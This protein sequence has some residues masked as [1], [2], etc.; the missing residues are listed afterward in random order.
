MNKDKAK[1]YHKGA[2]GQKA[3]VEVL[4]TPP[5]NENDEKD[6]SNTRGNYNKLSY[7]DKLNILERYF[8]F[9]QNLL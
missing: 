4:E 1:K 6:I 5:K 7:K 9:K 3:L 8:V 2:N